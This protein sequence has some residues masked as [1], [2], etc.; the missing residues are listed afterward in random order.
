MGLTTFRENKHHEMTINLEQYI[1][2]TENDAN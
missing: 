2:N 1:F